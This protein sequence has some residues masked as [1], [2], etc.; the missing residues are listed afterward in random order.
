[1][2]NE[3]PQYPQSGS[4]PKGGDGLFENT[5]DLI[6]LFSPDG[7]LLDVNPSWRRVLERPDDDITQLSVFSVVH[8]RDHDGFRK[9]VADVLKGQSPRKIG[10]TMVSQSN[11]EIIAEG[12]VDLIGG[13]QG[14]KVLRCILHDITKRRKYDELKDEFVGTISHELRTPLTVVRKEWPRSDAFSAA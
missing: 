13:H 10:I 7:I 4:G 11:R 9:A 14:S 2:T 8:P 3:N 12:S 5:H 6:Q 1:M